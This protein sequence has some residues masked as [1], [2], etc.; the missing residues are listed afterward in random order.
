M[1]KSKSE[2]KVNQI[3]LFKSKLRNIHTVLMQAYENTNGFTTPVQGDEREVVI[4]ELLE[5]V[6]PQSYRLGKG[7][8]I[9]RH[10]RE[11]GQVDA[12]FEKPFSLSFPI[13]SETNRLY[14]ADSVAAAFEIKSNLYTQSDE[15]IA[16][17][18]EIKHLR[19]EASTGAVQFYDELFVPTFIIG[20]KGHTTQ[21]GIYQ[22]FMPDLNASDHIN[23]VL[24]IDSG[25]FVGRSP[26]R[27]E[28]GKK[29]SGGWYQLEGD[30]AGAILCFLACLSD[31]LRHLERKEI[32]LLSYSKLLE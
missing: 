29:I 25:V 14:L 11:T 22:K 24:V 4:R 18:K 9:D 6:L 19:R 3:S 1:G 13:S 20:F 16:K 30:P 17:A 2:T 31:T 32:D 28:N 7:A 10:G 5:L 15:A 26:T 23:A 12:V 8:I 21:E 27:F